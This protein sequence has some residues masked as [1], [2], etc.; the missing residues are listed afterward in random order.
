M[1]TKWQPN[2]NQMAPQDSI[3]KLSIDKDSIDKVSKGKNNTFVPPSVDEVR[4]Y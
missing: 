4:D 1:A 2:G 3:G